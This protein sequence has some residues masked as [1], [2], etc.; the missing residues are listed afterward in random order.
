M[1]PVASRPLSDVAARLPASMVDLFT[2][3]PFE[4]HL[5]VTVLQA[6]AT[7]GFVTLDRVVTLKLYMPSADPGS[8]QAVVRT[9]VDMATPG[10]QTIVI[11]IP[12]VYGG[13]TP[14]IA[15]AASKVLRALGFVSN[16]KWVYRLGK[17][18]AVT[19]NH[20]RA[21]T[22]REVVTGKAPGVETACKDITMCGGVQYLN[23]QYNRTMAGGLDLDDS[24]LDQHQYWVSFADEG[25]SHPCAAAF[26]DRTN[27]GF[28]IDYLC[29]KYRA[30]GKGLFDHMREEAQASGAAE[31]T[32]D[33]MSDKLKALYRGTYGMKDKPPSLDNFGETLMGLDLT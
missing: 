31:I 6:G 32:L 24:D 11:I 7:L 4:P 3:A 30:T 9:A 5:P 14:T 13:N 23:S 1:E 15:A 26:V 20:V 8:L 28:H 29:A 10:Q 25:Y 2:P 22:V 16:S 12:N 17:G 33:A 27:G 21:Y 18:P 19:C